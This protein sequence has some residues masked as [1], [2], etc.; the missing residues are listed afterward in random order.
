M[1]EINNGKQMRNVWEIKPPSRDEKT[2]GKHPTQKPLELLKRIILASTKEE[3]H[4]LD[5]FCG[6]STTGVACVLLGRKYMGIDLEEKYLETSKKRI[7]D[8]ISKPQLFDDRIK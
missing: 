6:S 8:V 1:K 2:Y 3:D 4:V 5:P 7:E